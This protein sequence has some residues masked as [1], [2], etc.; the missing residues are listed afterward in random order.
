MR[1]CLACTVEWCPPSSEVAPL[2][3]SGWLPSA[4]ATLYDFAPLGMTTVGVPMQAR[5]QLGGALRVGALQAY[6][7][8]G[9]ARSLEATH[10]PYPQP[11]CGC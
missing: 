9:P 8:G 6:T 3:P 11:S 5:L 4:S 2:P 10:H 1:T 7:P